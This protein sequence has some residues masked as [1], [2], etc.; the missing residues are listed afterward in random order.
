M[1]GNPS[2]PFQDA[3]AF[4]ALLPR[5]GSLL[6]LDLSPRRIGFAGTDAGR[7]LVT[8]LY[9]FDR[10]R[11]DTDLAQVGSLADQRSTVGIVLGWPLNMDGT[12]GPACD[13]VRSFAGAL[14]HRLGLPVLLQDERLTTAAVDLALEEG[15]YPRPRRGLP[16]DHLVAAVILEDALRAIVSSAAS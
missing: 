1:H 16:V 15:R 4:A 3:G 8:P 12:A 14:R 6:A 11:L 13:R 10:R 7:A 9:T 2:G 5:Q